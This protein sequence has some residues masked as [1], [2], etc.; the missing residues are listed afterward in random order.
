MPPLKL[1]PLLPATLTFL[2]LISRHVVA[3]EEQDTQIV[4]RGDEPTL[5]DELSDLLQSSIWLEQNKTDASEVAR[6]CCHVLNSTLPSQVFFPDSAEY[7]AQQASYYSFEQSDLEPTCRVS[8][9]SAIDVS[10]IV[11]LA[12]QYD[13]TFAVRSGGHMISQG[14]SNVDAAGFTIDLQKMNSVSLLDGGSVVSFGSGCRWHE[15]YSALTPRNLTTVGGRASDVGV[16][17]FLLGGGISALSLA[18]GFGSSNIVNYQ[19]VLADGTIHDV[20]GQTLPDLYWALKYGSTNFGIVTRFDMTTYPLSDVWAG[21]LLFDISRGPAILQAHV[22]FTAKLSEDP[23]GLNVVGLAWEPTQKAY[24]VWSPNIYL[25]PTPFPPLYSDIEPLVPHAFLD[26]MRVTDLA[27]ITDEFQAMAP[28]SGRVQWFTLTLKA[29]ATLL[30]DI[31][32]KGVE[33]FEPYLHRSGFTWAAVFQPLNRGFAAA[34]ERNGGNPSGISSEDGDLVVALGMALWSDREDD[35][36]LQAKT[37]ELWR[38]AENTARE[39]GLL[40]PFIYMNYAS[41]LQ[42]VMGSIG[43]KN[44]GRMRGIKER[45]DPSNR[46]GLYWKGGYKLEAAGQV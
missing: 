5:A 39:R 36:V 14:F 27:S 44:L 16:S 38:W 46:F 9:H 37:H 29:D 23:M 1:W 30:W 25:A 42:D 40:H 8:P 20:N 22:E 31:H 4:F 34:S 15:V 19:V 2:C 17:G 41:K 6:H 28:G 7:R 35:E 24:I 33:I 18:H 43:P 26:T 11:S 13:C 3:L 45:Y 21:T 10:A 12:T 32:L